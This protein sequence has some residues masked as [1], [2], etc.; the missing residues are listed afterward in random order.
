MKHTTKHLVLTSLL[1]GATI[2]PTSIETAHAQPQTALADAKS[3]LL[4]SLPS[5][6]GKEAFS[7]DWKPEQD[8][9]RGSF[10]LQTE[11]QT[12]FIRSVK[13][14]AIMRRT[15]PLAAD[16]KALVVAARVRVQGFAQGQNPWDIMLLSVGFLGA[17]GKSMANPGALHSGSAPTKIGKMKVWSCRCSRR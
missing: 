2:S 14:P 8:W 7:A 12:R 16:D 11:N 3:R 9:M 5:A 6:T 10:S 15:F 13:A 1:L 17:D 4:E